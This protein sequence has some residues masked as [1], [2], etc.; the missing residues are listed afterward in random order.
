[1]KETTKLKDQA[2][3]EINSAPDLKHLEQIRVNYLGKKGKLTEQLKT[4]GKLPAEERPKAGQ[5]INDVKILLND[6]S[7]I[8]GNKVKRKNNIDIISKAGFTPCKTKVKIKNFICPIWQIESEKMLHDYELL[9]LYQK[10]SKLRVFNL[11]VFYTP[12]LL[13]PSPLRKDRKSGFLTPSINL[14]F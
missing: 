6:G 2:L 8:V 7:R 12:Y 1:M 4:L 10:H 13:T 9:F 14:N 3:L 5:V 11:P